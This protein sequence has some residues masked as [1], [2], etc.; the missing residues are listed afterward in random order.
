MRQA[1]IESKSDRIA[2]VLEAEI[3]MG[4]LRDG[5]PLSSEA[6]LVERFNVS[7]ST[8][9][10]GLGL[11]AAK[12]LILTRVGIG[13]FVTYRGTQIDSQA[14]WSLSLPDG[15]ARLGMRILRIVRAPMD[16]CAPGPE[17]EMLHVDRIR[18]LEATGLGLTF[19]RARLPWRGSFE[20]LLDGLEGGSLSQSLA[21]RGISA[22]S[23][24]E[25]AGVLP[26]LSTEDAQAMGRTPGEPMLRL[27]RL[28]RDA[29]GAVIE[30]VESLLDPGQFGLHMEF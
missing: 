23:G 18:F 13:S 17:G 14:G 7:R 25:W 6:A 4:A 2:R 5:D 16:L 26:A 22:A 11:L 21:S 24:E 15:D 12:G 30:Y 27:R 3:R 8:V 1:S 29:G 28:T 9:R 20:P 10:K 19:E